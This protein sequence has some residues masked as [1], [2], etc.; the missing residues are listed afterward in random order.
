MPDPWYPAAVR[1][2]GVNA[3]Y[4]AGRTLTQL[5]VR[6]YTVGTDS[7]PIGMAGY[8]N[9]LISRDGTVTQFAEVDALTWHAGEWNGYGPGIEVEYLD[10]P[11]VFTPEALAAAQAL[12]RWLEAEWGIEP[13]QYLG[14][15]IPTTA[16]FAGWIDHASL[17]QTEEHYDFW[18][19]PAWDVI[20]QPLPVPPYDDEEPE[21][22]APA[23]LYLEKT[24]EVIV[25][26]FGNDS[27]AYLGR[28]ARAAITAGAFT[29]VA[30]GAFVTP[31]EPKP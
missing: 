29:K 21:M 25:A 22:A 14:P 26:G 16:G 17:I 1:Q 24:D 15:R 18:P 11:D 9:F 19:Q 10:E 28:F 4:Q 5:V 27:G 8:F 20:C 31:G 3:G 2:P 30:A 7:R 12:Y 6:H 23:L 13:G